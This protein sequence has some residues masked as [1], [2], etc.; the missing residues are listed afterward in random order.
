MM[1]KIS[2]TV[3]VTFILTGIRVYAQWNPVAAIPGPPAD[4]A[5]AFTINSK[6][7]VAGGTGRNLLYMYDPGTNTWTKKANI[8]GSSVRAWAGSFTYN[9]RAYVVGGDTSFGGLLK[10]MWAYDPTADSWSRKADFPGGKRDGMLCWVI[11]NRVYVGG[12]FNGSLILNDFY[13]YDPATDSWIQLN[14]MSSPVL[15]ASSFVIDGKG[16]AT[17]WEAGA[18]YSD[19][20]V[21]DPAADT[22]TTKASCPGTARGEGVGFTLHGKGYAGLGQTGFNQTYT[23]FYEYDPGADSWRSLDSFPMKNTGWSTAFVIGNSAYVGMGATLPDFTFT[24]KFYKHDFFATGIGTIQDESILNLYPNPSSG[25]L[26]ISSTSG[27]AKVGIFDVSGKLLWSDNA[28]GA[29]EYAAYIGL[30]AGFY[31]VRIQTVKGISNH[32]LIMH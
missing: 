4:G 28:H 19:L 18:F 23:D 9:N 1:K 3:L 6:G 12:G 30:S 29:K 10:D 16:Y 25:G 2:M 26:N 27:I 8:P 7:Y 11:G 5:A 21:Y 13:S 22:W 32:R 14:N 15:F 20:I 17:M 31:L 24:N